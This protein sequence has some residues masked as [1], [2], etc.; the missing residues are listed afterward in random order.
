MELGEHEE[1]E[2]RAREWLASVD[3]REDGETRE[4]AQALDLY[5]EALCANGRGAT[6]A[7]RNLAERAVQIRSASPNFGFDLAVSKANL[8]DV[9]VD[10]GLYNEGAQAH[11][12]ALAL[13]EQFAVADPAAVADSLSRLGRALTL[14]ERF[15]EAKQVLRRSIEILEP[16][17]GTQARLLATVLERLTAVLLQLDE[18]KE[19]RS[20]IERAQTL[21]ATWWTEHPD[22]VLSLNILGDVEWFEGHRPEAQ[23]EYLRALDLAGR[24][25]RADHP[26]VALT[27]RNLASASAALGELPRAR[28]LRER[29]LRLAEQ[30][31]GPTHPEV[32]GHLNDFANSL[33][34]EGD[35]F[36]ARPLR[37]R[38]LRITE[39]YFGRDSLRAA[40]FLNNLAILHQ[41]LGDLDSATHLQTRA[42]AIWQR[43][44]GPNH[45]FV[46]RA[47]KL[48]ADMRLD[49]RREIDALRLYERAL[50]IQKRS[51]GPTHV[52]IARTRASLAAVLRQMGRVDRADGLLTDAID[53]WE[54]QRTPDDPGLARARAGLG[55]VQMDGGRV[56][57]ARDTLQQALEA[58]QRIFSRSHPETAILRSHLAEAEFAL[59]EPSSALTSTLQAEADGRAHLHMTIRDL[60]E[61][62]ALGYAA[63]RPRGLDVAL[64]ILAAG[65]ATRADADRV[66]S[67]L[68]QSRAAVLDEIAARHRTPD[69][70]SA[71]LAN[72][73]A[74]LAAARQRLANVVVRGPESMALERYNA[75][76]ERARL[77]KEE[78][79]QALAEKSARFRDELAR[80]RIGSNEIRAGLS[81]GAALVAFVRYE[82]RL[83]ESLPPASGASTAPP[84]GAGASGTKLRLV[85]SYLA[86][87]VRPDGAGASAV[88][89][90]DART[91]ERLVTRWRSEVA[92]GVAQPGRSPAGAER[93]YRAAG[94]ALRQSVW[95]PLIP[96]LAGAERVLVV[97]DGAL[98]LV[99][100]AALPTG[101]TAFLV[102]QTPVIHYLSAERD[103]VAAGPSR[104][105]GRGLLAVGNP[106][107]DERPLSGS[108]NRAAPAGPTRSQAVPAKPGGTRASGTVPTRGA[109][110][111]GT[112][113]AACGT[114]ASMQFVALPATS[115]EAAAVARTWSMQPGS[116]TPSEGLERESARILAG[117]AASER[118]FKQQAPGHRV[119]HLATHGFF[120]GGACTSAL[121]TSTRGVGGLSAA[122]RPV[123]Y[124]E[125]PLILSGLALAGAN[126]RS[127]ARANG[128]DGILT[129]EEIAGLDLGGVEWAV[130]SA[131]DTG[132]GEIKSGEG[133]FGLRRA[134]HVAGAR[135]IIMSLW[136]VEDES[137]LRWMRALYEGRMGKGFDTAT[138][139][140]EASLAVLRARRSQHQTTHPFYWAAFVAAGDWR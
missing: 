119:L 39:Q 70:E 61:R 126:L 121:G 54:R 48:L 10:S 115:R 110:A 41:R 42:V 26:W 107:F 84:A 40:T 136:S 75:L 117:R 93:A 124:G 73:R 112:T 74:T 12:Q 118:V 43:H 17:A 82:R 64:S 33:H 1:A 92:S 18:V 60:P 94:Q 31:L 98:N 109:A 96:A 125:S 8:A 30:A 131:C 85:P 111:E 123:G 108:P 69:D 25:L 5:V 21:R 27:L 49:Q 120:L 15:P 57:Q 140:R 127:A 97:P 4:T 38:A 87:V 6:P 88:P 47:L 35:Y 79:E 34:V 72:V 71:E 81:P 80:S 113:R 67:E 9:L 114:F 53:I 129:A 116:T 128:E 3:S 135:T 14:A 133:V 65:Q 2:R 55:L 95:D 62:V 50:A 76:V 11:R 45:A 99:S 58:H 29:A 20:S 90:G 68:V 23:R 86:F 52:E 24:R 32:A 102:E 103:L 134:L 13:R 19:A 105:S 122:A 36:G 37:A 46:A 89:L 28:D 137:A 16:V 139:V 22:G 77:Q 91:I 138:A 104:A 101:L 132:I 63:A 130:L 100:L 51:L 59:E 106:A 56:S 66:F 7:S 78:A 83:V 44:L